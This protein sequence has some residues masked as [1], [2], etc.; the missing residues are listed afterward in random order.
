[1]AIE[2]YT[3]K[4]DTTLNGAIS[5]TS[6]T[7]I[8]VTDGSVFPSVG[9]F[10]III[11]S[12]IMKVTARSTNTLTVVRGQEG[13]TAATH[14]DLAPVTDVLT[15]QSFLNLLGE[16]I[17]TGTFA[18]RPAAERPGRLYLPTDG[19]SIARDDGTNWVSC[20]PIWG[21]TP[22]AFAGGTWMN[23]GSYGTVS[24]ELDGCLFGDAGGQTTTDEYRFLHKTIAAPSSPWEFTAALI[25]SMYPQ[26]GGANVGIAIG[27]SSDNKTYHL[28]N[29]YDAVTVTGYGN[30][31]R[32]QN[33]TPGSADATTQSPKGYFGQISFFRITKDASNITFYVSRDFRHW[34]QR[35]Q[36]ALGSSHVGSAPNWYGLTMNNFNTSAGQRSEAF[37]LE[38]YLR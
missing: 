15:K 9:N 30:V 11:D 16:G 31:Y 33:G 2:Q 25:P 36:V 7:S 3:N 13:T 28:L 21:F 27:N 20:G 32:G 38:A 4:A 12:E 5:S 37:F 8:V 10:R 14:L 24:D 29:Q 23:Q 22:P 17:A 19:M 18:S 1:M 26:G 6:S 35:F 34:M